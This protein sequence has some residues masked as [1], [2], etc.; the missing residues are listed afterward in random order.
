MNH[1]IVI[2]YCF[3]I[4]MGVWQNCSAIWVEVEGTAVITDAGIGKAR[5][6]AISDAIRQAAVQA[7]AHVQSES[8]VSNSVLIADSVKVRA[9]GKVRNVK[10]IDEWKD[11]EEELYTVLIRADVVED[12]QVQAQAQKKN[13]QYRRKLA[14]LQFNVLDRRQTN[15]VPNIE[16]T[17]AKELARRMAVN[18]QFLV[19]DATQYSFSES[20]QPYRALGLSQREILVTL[21]TNLGVQFIVTGTIMDM[22]T[23]KHPLFVR[24][25]HVELEIKVWDGIAGTLVSQRRLNGSVWDNHLFN[26]PT[27]V[28]AMNDKFYASPIGQETNRILTVLISEISNDINVLP[29][30]A[31][32]LRSVGKSVYLDVGSMSDIQVGDVLMS[33]KLAEDPEFAAAGGEFLGF[34]EQPASVIVVKKVQP[35]FSIGELE[36]ATSTLNPGDVVRVAW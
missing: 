28:P 36:S 35:N 1:K 25:R 22:G 9:A 6:T 18:Q 7:G 29:F 31:R 3:V 16:V 32:V 2:L 34:P 19:K 14:V 4:F 26:F 12:S 23:T 20:S 11:R 15:D 27:S 10:I 5:Q 13:M 17:M 21:A 33:Y 30:T 24:L 8:E